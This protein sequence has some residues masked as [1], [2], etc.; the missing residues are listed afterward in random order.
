MKGDRCTTGNG[1]P[2]RWLPNLDCKFGYGAVAVR[3]LQV[4][5]EKNAGAE[6]KDFSLM[7][8]RTSTHPNIHHLEPKIPP[9]SCSRL[10][11]PSPKSCWRTQYLEHAVSADCLN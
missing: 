1:V 7:H 9:L 6:F 8:S 11:S 10:K 2:L 3:D 5:R 4:S